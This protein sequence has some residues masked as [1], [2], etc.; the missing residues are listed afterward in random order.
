MQWRSVPY[1]VPSLF[2]AAV[3]TL[4]GCSL[5]HVDD[6][7]PYGVLNNNDLQ[8]VEDGLPTYLLMVDGLIENWPESESLLSSGA[9][10]YGAYAGLFVE[11][12]ERARKLSNKALD[13]GFRAACAH[14][15]D[16]CDLR[17][18]SVPEFESLLDDAGKG[19]VPVLFSLGGAWAGYI[20]QNTSDW[21]AVAELGRVEAIMARIVA[22][23]EGY[24]YGQAHM[25]LGVLNSILPASLGGKPEQAKAHFEEAV[26]L[27]DGK[28]LLAQVLYAEKYA[29]LVFDRELHDSLL[30]EVLAADPD[31]HGLTLQNTYAQQQAEALLADADDYF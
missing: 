10:L 8:L 16:Y 27:S 18:L 20:Q 21:N 12:P 23:D 31:V 15:K 17:S 30:N 3:I 4:Q 9:D 24:Q 19:D 26:L 6:N 29:R 5:A 11:E 25:Y 13:Y 28:N 2:F 22:L 14:H 7:L 1:W